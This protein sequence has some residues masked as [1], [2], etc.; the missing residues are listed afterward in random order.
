M[1]R[2][3]SFV[4][5]SSSPSA[6][7]PTSRST[8]SARTWTA[9]RSSVVSFSAARSTGITSC[10]TICSISLLIAQHLRRPV[11][12]GLG[13]GRRAVPARQERHALGDHLEPR[14]LL[15]GRAL[16]ALL[17]EPALDDHRPA[18]LAVGADHLALLIPGRHVH[19]RRLLVGVAV[20][21][22]PAAV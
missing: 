13:L 22:E 7:S 21:V 11:G 15:A 12:Q 5:S 2:A 18:L 6:S 8:R 16:P 1:T 20:D 4:S 19:E 9:P 3:A 10:V 14:A 17:L